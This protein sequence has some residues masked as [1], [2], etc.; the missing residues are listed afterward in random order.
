MSSKT[1]VA[2][3]LDQL[4]AAKLIVPLSQ[5]IRLF[6]VGSGGTGSWLAPAVARVARLLTEKFAKDV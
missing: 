5:R 4:N 1:Q 2:L 3:N 6:L